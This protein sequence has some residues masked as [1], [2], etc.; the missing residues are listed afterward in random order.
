[1]GVD[2]RE[3]EAI[4]EYVEVKAHETVVHLE[5]VASELVG[6]TRHDIWDVI[7][8]DSRWWVVTNPTFLYSQA[9]FK[10]RDVVL[11]FHIGLML[12]TMY[13]EERDVPV[14]PEPARLLPGSWR[15]WQQAFEAY[16]SGDEA[17]NFQAVGMRLRECLLSF[18][19][20]TCSDELVHERQVHPKAADFKGWIDLLANQLAP[21]DSACRLRSYL[22]KTAGETWDLTNWL[23]HAKSAIRLDAEI[24]LK[25]VEH[26]LGAF[27]AARM[28]FERLPRRCEACGSYGV[29]AGKCSHCAWIDPTYE[30][31]PE[32]PLL[33]DEELARRLAKPCTPSSDISTFLS[34]DDL[35]D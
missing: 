14:A 8:A 35:R 13:L 18:I 9:D 21:G 33:S 19:G 30:P 5:K 27:T 17:E 12:R 29:I 25:A 11:S 34:P 15:R 2:D 6:P 1:V 3:R 4:R 32:P 16:D 26:V 7:G 20:E 22:K 10:S 24:V 28:R 23:T 31:A